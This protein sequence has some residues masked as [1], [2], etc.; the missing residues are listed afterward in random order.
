M[1][2]WS[3][4]PNIIGI[5]SSDISRIPVF[6]LRGGRFQ[7]CMEGGFDSCCFIRM[8]LPGMMIQLPTTDM[9]SYLW[10]K[11]LPDKTS[12]SRNDIKLH[13]PKVKNI[14]LSGRGNILVL[15]TKEVAGASMDVSIQEEKRK[16]VYQS[17]KSRIWCFRINIR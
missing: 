14:H 2:L 15:F 3:K 7:K 16:Y 9:L 5:E 12:I 13:F 10:M 17:S 6:I 11:K 8:E 1:L 4:K